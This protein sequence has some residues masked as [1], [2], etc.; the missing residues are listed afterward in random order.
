[1]DDRDRDQTTVSPRWIQG[2]VLTFLVGFAILG[3]L[4]IRVYEEHPPIPAKVVS[5][6]GDML[7]TGEDI[8]DGQEL[9]LTYGLMQYGSIYGH[10]PIS[11]P[12]SPPI[13]CIARRC[14][15]RN[16]TG[17]MPTRTSRF[18]TNCEPIVTIRPHHPNGIHRRR[19]EPGDEH[20][21]RLGGHDRGGHEDD[22]S[23]PADHR[24]RHRRRDGDRPPVKHD[25]EV[26][27]H[28]HQVDQRQVEHERGIALGVTDIEV[29]RDRRREGEHRDAVEDPEP[30]PLGILGLGDMERQMPQRRAQD[31]QRR[32]DSAPGSGVAWR[33]GGGDRRAAAG[34]G[35]RWYCEIGRRVPGHRGPG[36][37]ESA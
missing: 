9:F 36:C 17:E 13:T 12:T 35:R 30:G 23:D 8:R 27:R 11:V 20:L 18:A 1:M 4:A 31:P 28:Q 10:V 21:P 14:R 29:E 37:G 5:E 3:Y 26:D 34:G 32:A 7:F 33:P 2:I 22:R 25:A 15:C 19:Q 24:P 16:S 6:R